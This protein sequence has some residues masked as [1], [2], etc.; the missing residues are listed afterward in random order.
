V[1]AFARTCE[2]Q[3]ADAGDELGRGQ[4]AGGDAGGSVHTSLRVRV[5]GVA[6]V[7]AELPGPAGGAHTLRHTAK[8]TPYSVY[9]SL[10]MCCSHTFCLAKVIFE[11][12]FGVGRRR[13]G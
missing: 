3:R 4:R 8:A 1:S 12:A 7:L 5:T 11:D 2:A 13:Q 6:H 9:R 10:P